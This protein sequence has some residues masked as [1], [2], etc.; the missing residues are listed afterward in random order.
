MK[1]AVLAGNEKFEIKEGELR[2]KKNPIIKVTHVGVCGTDLSYWKDGENYKDVVIGHE[3]SG[4]IEE[5]GTT[6]LFKKGDR[7][8]GYTQNVQNEPCGRCENCI[9]GDFDNCINR[10]VITWKGGEINH[11]GAYSQYTTWFP[12]S[13]YKLPDNVLNEEAAL[14]E[15]FTVSLHAAI[16]T[17]VKPG[18]KVIILGGGII[19]LG[20]AEWVRIFGAAEITITEINTEK[21]EVIK[22]YKVADHVI[23][24]DVKD[25]N[26]QLWAASDGGYDIVFDCA[27]VASALNAGIK[28]LKKEKKKKITC[29]ALPHSDLLL[30]YRDIV[31]REIIMK[32]SKGHTPEEFKAVINA[33]ENN[34]IKLKK[35]ISKKIKFENLQQGFEELKER[36]G[37]ETKAI[38]EMW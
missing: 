2:V 21:I 26:E 15:P 24:A 33:V 9:R 11:P 20:V 29:I 36:G 37:L 10:K 23:K 12:N 28:A 30:N 3:Y 1:Y 19:G 31:L 13:I 5:P 38:I 22:K 4:I 8:V 16:L 14:I 35:Y 17:E 7:V 25:L 32:G 27:G 34:R 18:D 6:D